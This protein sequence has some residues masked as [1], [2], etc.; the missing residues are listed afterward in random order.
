VK[1]EDCLNQA[2]TQVTGKR[3]Q[4]YGTPEN[5]FQTIADFWNAYLGAKYRVV[6]GTVPTLDPTDVTLMMDLLKTARLVNSPNHADS[7]ID[8]AGYSACG[9]EVSDA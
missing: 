8:K 5:N 3:T 4:D 9:A 6:F 7:W 1:R 2:M